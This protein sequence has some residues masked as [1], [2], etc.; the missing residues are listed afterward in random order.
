M[1]KLTPAQT[2]QIRRL[3]QKAARDLNDKILG[4]ESVRPEEPIRADMPTTRPQ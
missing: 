3:A 2:E 1:S 4:R